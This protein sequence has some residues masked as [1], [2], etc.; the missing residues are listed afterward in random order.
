MGE[1]AD[2]NQP[3]ADRTKF[4]EGHVPVANIHSRSHE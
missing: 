1:N 2:S 3:P 4:F